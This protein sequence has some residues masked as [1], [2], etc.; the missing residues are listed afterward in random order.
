MKHAVLF[1]WTIYSVFSDTFD[2]FFD[3]RRYF[4]EHVISHSSKCKTKLKVVSDED[5]VFS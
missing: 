5:G 4:P 1:M 3:V 2:A